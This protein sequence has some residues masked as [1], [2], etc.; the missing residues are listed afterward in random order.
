MGNWVLVVLALPNKHI[1]LKA[2]RGCRSCAPRWAHQGRYANVARL[3]GSFLVVSSIVLLVSCGSPSG[4]H[5]QPSPSASGGV[6]GI[7]L[8]NTL[9]S[10]VR[11]SATELPGGFGEWEGPLSPNAV[12]TVKAADGPRAG[13]VVAHTSS[14]DQG[15][16]RVTL[17][18]GRYRVLSAAMP[19]P[20]RIVVTPGV[21]TRIKIFGSFG[22]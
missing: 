19:A 10:S 11:Y 15:L 14:D 7:T 17:P 22:M 12:V 21:F 20:V 8:V 18:P 5:T 16:F 13:Q 9:A 2:A 3:I 4:R 1:N 6:Y